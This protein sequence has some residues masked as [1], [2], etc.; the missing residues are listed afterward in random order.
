MD[1]PLLAPFQGARLGHERTKK[2]EYIKNIRK[3]EL[4]PCAVKVACTVPL[5]GKDAK[6]LPIQIR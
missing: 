4:E 5:G 3:T 1:V 6:S 2:Q